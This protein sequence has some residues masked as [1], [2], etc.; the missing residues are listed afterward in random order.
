VTLFARGLLKHLRTRLY[1]ADAGAAND[2]DPVL[3]AI[4]DPA[5]RK[6]LLATPLE[7]GGKDRVYRFDIVL[8]GAGETAFFEV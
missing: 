1:F 4:E 5:A 2:A 6:S 7:G 8:Q 3:S